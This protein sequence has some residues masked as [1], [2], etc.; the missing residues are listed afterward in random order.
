MAGLR[1]SDLQVADQPCALMTAQESSAGGTASQLP[2]LSAGGL[3]A[4]QNETQS[5]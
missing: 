3:V 5:F 2:P 1:E 4:P